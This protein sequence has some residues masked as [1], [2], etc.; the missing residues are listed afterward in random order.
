MISAKQLF[1]LPDSLHEFR[2]FF[3]PEV[4]PWKWVTQIKGALKSFESY[5][6]KETAEGAPLKITGPVYIHPSVQ[7]PHFGT[8]AG[9]CWIGP[10]CELRPGV[11][12]RG[13]VIAGANCLLGNSCEFKNALLMDDVQVAH[14]NYVGDS[15][16]GNHSHLGAGAV[17]S[18]FR[19]D[20]QHIPIDL[21]DDTRIS[22][23][24]R[25]LGSMLGEN[26]Q[27]GCNAVAQPGSIIGKNAVV[28]TG[29]VHK[30]F[31]ASDTWNCG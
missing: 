27:L 31:L 20:G 14:F 25:K 6:T 4:E 17:L 1:T 22:S 24:M 16:M 28:L 15:I 21:E 10:N 3:V 26:A 7:L 11:F 23:E 12:I 29:V 2:D 5:N 30:G 9:P 8:I 13:N 18:N 19:I